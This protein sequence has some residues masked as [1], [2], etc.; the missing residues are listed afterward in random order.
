MIKKSIIYILAVFSFY[1]LGL[2]DTKN[3]NYTKTFR[4]I[5]LST[6]GLA[7][8]V[9][10]TYNSRSLY[11]GMFGFGW[12]SNL[13]TRLDVLPDNTLM[14]VECGGGAEIIYTSNKAPGN[15]QL[16]VNKIMSVV[17]NKKGLP[18]KYIKQVERDVKKSGA[19]RSELIRAFG[20]KGKATGGQV[21]RALGR[22]NE[23]ISL[24][25]NQY[26]RTLPNGIIQL[27]S[28]NGLLTRIM[29]KSGNWINIQRRK[30]RI[31]KVIDNRGRS[32]QFQ[33]GKDGGLTIRGPKGLK[34]QYTIKADNLVQVTNARGER[35]Q[36]FY[37]NY[38]NLTKT[39][40]PDS[41]FEALTYNTDKDWVVSFKNRRACIER[42]KYNTNN[43]NKNHYWTD[44]K[45]TCGKRVTNQSRYEFW[46]RQKPD[47]TKYLF[48]ARQ[49]VNGQVADM[50]YDMKT[51]APL[52]ITRNG[53]TTRYAYNAQG[54]LKSRSDA[55]RTV[56]F[57]SY[58]NR[59]K[60]PTQVVIKYMQRN[61]VS[62]EVKTQIS[63]DPKKCHLMMARQNSTG[64]WV[65][66]KRD[67]RGRIT[68]MQDQSK[69]RI[70][71][72]YNEK[73]GKPQMIT[74]PG[75]GSI[76]VFYDQNGRVDSSKSTT[77]PTVAAQVASVF[78]G[79]LEII[80]PVAQNVT[81]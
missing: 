53:V 58:N 13:E 71:V 80:S 48:R 39:R 16:T 18:K 26:R 63:Y 77:N 29:D 44:V 34:A 21:Y 28:T 6:Q 11:N 27:F 9:E 33:W 49:S 56:L 31:A 1:A 76:K 30:G 72:A 54:F 79:F 32:L 51:G 25:G 65:S 23:T 38:H 66:V 42:Y 74:R 3:A 73:Y 36:H 81:I 57:S 60:K 20:L 24:Q 67:H 59:C 19:L 61:K 7:L 43:K 5:S 15:Q 37:D 40:Y 75:V 47:G 17:R 68:E 64:R 2:V 35:Y 14:L 78:N 8:M 4:D 50:T 41:T 55:T 70:L 46:N 45:K 12:C 52:R 10:R 62:R 22:Q 69:K